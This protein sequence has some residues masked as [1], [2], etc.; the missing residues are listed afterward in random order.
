[1]VK[2]T[3]NQM[4][5]LAALRRSESPFPVSNS[6][7]KIRNSIW[8]MITFFLGGERSIQLSYRNLCHNIIK[9]LRGKHKRNKED[10][11]TCSVVGKRTGSLCW[12]TKKDGPPQLRKAVSFSLYGLVLTIAPVSFPLLY[13]VPVSATPFT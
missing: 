3:M 1:M 7:Q 11:S 4:T 2:K 6:E 12:G 10:L 5:L 13:L 8:R 9:A